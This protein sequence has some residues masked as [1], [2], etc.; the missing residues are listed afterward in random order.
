[1][2]HI[3]YL[4]NNRIK[5]QRAYNKGLLYGFSATY[6]CSAEFKKKPYKYHLLNRENHITQKMIKLLYLY[7]SEPKIYFLKELPRTSLT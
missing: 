2:R 3:N 4:S 5:A 1:L 6:V 7:L